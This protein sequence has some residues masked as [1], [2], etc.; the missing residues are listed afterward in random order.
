MHTRNMHMHIP[1]VYILIESFLTPLNLRRS[2]VL[3][4]VD[5]MSERDC[6]HCE[7]PRAFLSHPISDIDY[8]LYSYS[9]IWIPYIF[10][11][12]PLFHLFIHMLSCVEIYIYYCSDQNLL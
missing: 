10:W 7:E 6:T 2:G 11:T 3:Y 5:Q 8:T 9:V 4:F 1:L 12:Q